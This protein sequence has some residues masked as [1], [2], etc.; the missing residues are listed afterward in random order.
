MSVDEFGLGEWWPRPAQAAVGALDHLPVGQWQALAAKWLA[1][2]YD[3]QPLRQLAKLP[4][5][6]TRAVWQDVLDLMPKA[7]R[8]IGF[9]PAP[10]DVEFRDRCQE[11]LDIVQHDLDATGYGQYRM[12]ARAVRPGVMYATFPDGSYW[13]GGEGMSRQMEG[14][15]LLSMRPNRYRPRSKS[16]TRSSGRSAPPTAMIPGLPGSPSP[17]SRRRR[18]GSA[19]APGMRLPQSASSPSRSPERYDHPTSEPTHEPKPTHARVPGSRGSPEE[20]RSRL[21]GVPFPDELARGLA[22]VA[23][24][25]GWP[26]DFT[27]LA[28]RIGDASRSA[29]VGVS[30]VGSTSVPGLAAKG[31]Y[32]CSGRGPGPR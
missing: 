23:Y 17:S 4:P 5:G 18:G 15:W 29:V 8:S 12:Q 22:V 26:G 14:S 9:D 2:G 13:G 19:P 11:A 1:A 7:M 20:V 3:S 25:C 16:G 27:V 6:D 31:L 30:H 24:E 21:A 10:A 32:R 28:S